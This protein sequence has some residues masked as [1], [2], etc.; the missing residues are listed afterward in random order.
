MTAATPS[1]TGQA[2]F[3]Q[4]GHVED[5]EYTVLIMSHQRSIVDFSNTAGN[6]IFFSC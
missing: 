3:P 4:Q 2:C 5:I 6:F 1:P